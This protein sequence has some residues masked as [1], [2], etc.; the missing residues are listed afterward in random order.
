[1]MSLTSL[2][3]GL[4]YS[5]QCTGGRAGGGEVVLLVEAGFPGRQLGAKPRWP[6]G[7]RREEEKRQKLRPGVPLG[8]QRIVPTPQAAR[9]RSLLIAR[10]AWRSTPESPTPCSHPRSTGEWTRT[11]GPEGRR[12]GVGGWRGERLEL[13]AEPRT[14]TSLPEG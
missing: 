8:A 1:M 7:P 2:L 14:G 11:R 10:P 12:R 13:Q 6:D 5:G 9:S 4:A 3:P